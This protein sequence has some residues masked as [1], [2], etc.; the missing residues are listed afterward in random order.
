MQ[1]ACDVSLN[2]ALKTYIILTS[3]TLMN[4]K[5]TNKQTKTKQNKKRKI[6]NL[7]RNKKCFKI[8]QSNKPIIDNTNGDRP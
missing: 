3:V 2:C 1:Y 7:I 4:L 8:V 5:Q 6:K